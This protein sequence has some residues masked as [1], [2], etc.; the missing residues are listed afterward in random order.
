MAISIFGL[1]ADADGDRTEALRLLSLAANNA[2]HRYIGD[3]A[4]VYVQFL[5]QQLA[6]DQ[7]DAR[8]GGSAFLDPPDHWSVPIR[9]VCPRFDTRQCKAPPNRLVR[10]QSMNSIFQS[11]SKSA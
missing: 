6:G 7:A 11:G 2:P 9:G 3:I 1:Y 4:R 8:G 10:G 5:K